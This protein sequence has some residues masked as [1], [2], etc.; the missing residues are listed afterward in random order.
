MTQPHYYIFV[1]ISPLKK[2][3][4]FIWTNLNSLHPK[5]ICFKFNFGLLVLEKKIFKIFQCI[6]TLLLLPSLGE[7]QSPLFEETWNH[8][9][10]GWFVPS[11]IKIGPVVLEKIFKWPHPIFVIISPLKRT[12]PFIWTKLNSLH[13]RIICTMLDWIWPAGSGE[14]DF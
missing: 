5:I 7:G 1:I 14:E 10:Q 4:P 2:T 12:C 6:F 3:W 9:S 11:L 13:P 8:S